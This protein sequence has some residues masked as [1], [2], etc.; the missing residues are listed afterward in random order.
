MKNK[1]QILLEKAVNN[2]LLKENMQ[3]AN[4]Y[5][6]ELVNDSFRYFTKR[7]NTLFQ[8]IDDPV[9]QAEYIK[10]YIYELSATLNSENDRRVS[11]LQGS[12]DGGRQ[13]DDVN[14]T[15]IGF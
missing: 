8:N 13:N 15:N 12:F 14:D 1:D 7:I 5:Y 11:K 2:I 6:L 9:K 10:K 3:K 4:S